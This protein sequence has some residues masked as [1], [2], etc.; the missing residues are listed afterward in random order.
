MLTLV[1]RCVPV[2]P[3]DKA[4]LRVLAPVN[5]VSQVY[6]TRADL[7]LIIIDLTT[8]YLSLLLTCTITITI[9]TPEDRRE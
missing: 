6:R 2:H 3:V 8:V 5:R 7:C 1:L 9:Q 4:E